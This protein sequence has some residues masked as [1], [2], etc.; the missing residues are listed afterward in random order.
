MSWPRRSF[1][2]LGIIVFFFLTLLLSKSKS[3]AL[4]SIALLSVIPPYLYRTLAGFADH[5]SIGMLGVFLSL[6]A[7]FYGMRYLS[8]K[9]PK[10]YISSIIGLVA[11]FFTMFAVASWGGGAK[12]LFMILP[13]AFIITWF[14][15]KREDNLSPVLFYSSWIAGIL[16]FCTDIRIRA[17]GGS[18]GVLCCRRPECCQWQCWDILL[19]IIYWR[20]IIYSRG[21]CPNTLRLSVQESHS[22]LG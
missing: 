10:H 3:V 21:N 6:A 5:D 13:L 9:N 15:K 12:F 1:F 14:M 18:K 2:V 7:F 19:F 22:F 20:V 8:R 16:S 4:A 11:G 17:S